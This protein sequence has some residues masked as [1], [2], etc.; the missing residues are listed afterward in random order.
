MFSQFEPFPFWISSW[1]HIGTT[2]TVS[3]WTGYPGV[4]FFLTLQGYLVSRRVFM[5]HVK[6]FFKHQPGAMGGLPIL[7]LKIHQCGAFKEKPTQESLCLQHSAQLGWC[8]QLQSLLHGKHDEEKPETKRNLATILL[9]KVVESR[10]VKAAV[11]QNGDTSQS[12]TVFGRPPYSNY[13]P[14]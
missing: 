1:C 13:T 7:S 4:Q 5:V 12:S 14:T 8:F 3:D 6:K 10:Q 11:Y 9:V 2:R